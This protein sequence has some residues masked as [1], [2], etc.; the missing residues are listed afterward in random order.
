MITFQNIHR[1]AILKSFFNRKARR[2]EQRVKKVV[3]YKH[4]IFGRNRFKDRSGYPS[5]A[6]I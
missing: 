5:W 2:E 3:L 1:S 4:F 6:D